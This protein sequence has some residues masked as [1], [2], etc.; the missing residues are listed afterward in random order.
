MKPSAR[1]ALAIAR[2]EQ[3][4]VD[5]ERSKQLLPVLMEEQR[6]WLEIYGNYSKVSRN[7]GFLEKIKQ[8]FSGK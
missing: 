5:R 1:R 2:A 8:F 6:R 3:R 4:R 7:P